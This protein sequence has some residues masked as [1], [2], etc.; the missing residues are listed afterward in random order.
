MPA[1]CCLKYSGK[2][3]EAPRFEYLKLK[4]NYNLMKSIGKYYNIKYVEDRNSSI[5]RH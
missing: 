4:I 1:C 3:K 5:T 2:K